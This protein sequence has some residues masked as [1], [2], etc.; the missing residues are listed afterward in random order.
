MKIELHTPVEQDFKAV[1]NQ[2][3]QDLFLKLAPAFPKLNLI[4][5]DGS[6]PGDM[7]IVEL[8]FM[9]FRQRWESVISERQE[10]EQ[11]AYFTDLGQKLPWPLR[12]WQH[13]HLVSK[14]IA[15]GAIVSDIIQ[16]R[17]FST[18]LDWLIYPIFRAQF[19]QRKP[20][21]TRVFAATK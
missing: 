3:N 10:T 19:A 9:L 17:T 20:I 5:F 21:Y 18:I 13:Q 1:F 16:F 15:G 12:Y 7:V 6:M 11:M 8:D 4:R 2:F 14:N